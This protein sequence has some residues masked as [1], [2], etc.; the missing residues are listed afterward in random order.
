ML[1]LKILGVLA[2][3]IL[4]IG[5]VSWLDSIYQEKFKIKLLSMSKT[6]VLFIS[7][8]MLFVGRE[9]YKSALESKGDKLNGLVLMIVAVMLVLGIIIYM[10]AT[11][12]IGYGTIAFF[13]YFGIFALFAYFGIAILVLMILGSIAE[14]VKFRINI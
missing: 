4:V 14:N 11:T 12:G 2:L 8:V 9:W 6:I 10:Y 1:V 5:L 7:G 3:I 13:V